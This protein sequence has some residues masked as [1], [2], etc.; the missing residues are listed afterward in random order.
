MTMETAIEELN[1]LSVGCSDGRC[2]LLGPRPGQH[3]NGGCGCLRNI[4]R[5]H[6]AMALE[7]WRREATTRRR[8]MRGES[9]G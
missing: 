4:P 3:T 5:V 1:F 6:I 2:V 8:A 7:A 9:D